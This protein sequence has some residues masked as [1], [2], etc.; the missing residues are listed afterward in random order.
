MERGNH[1]HIVT[2][3][4]GTGKTSLLD[5]LIDVP[6]D[7]VGEPARELIA[8]HRRPG[9]RGGWE[10]SAQGFQDRLL[11]LSIEKYRR[12]RNTVPQ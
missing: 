7:A 6:I 1:L 3:A 4:P 9:H 11:E 10:G 5:N 2:G 8:E 12:G